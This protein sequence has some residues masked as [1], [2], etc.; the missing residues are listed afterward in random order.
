M[1]NNIYSYNQF[2]IKSIIK[3]K[4]TIFENNQLMQI[5]KKKANILH[6]KNNI[7]SNN[8]K[9]ISKLLLKSENLEIWNSS[10]KFLRKK[11]YSLKKY[12]YSLS[13][14][15]RE[16]AKNLLPNKK[17]KLGIQYFYENQKIFGSGKGMLYS[18]GLLFNIGNIYESIISSQS[19]Y[20]SNIITRDIR[21]KLTVSKMF[22]PSYFRFPFMLDHYYSKILKISSQSAHIPI[23][24]NAHNIKET[25]LYLNYSG[26][27]YK[28]NKYWINLETS[29]YNELLIKHMLNL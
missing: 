14:N 7:L 2:N 22:H 27:K 16:F 20:Y 4:N 17:N 19:H 6:S 3:S 24:L 28:S 8:K 12:Y 26:R 13:K 18:H 11:D 29:Y 21:I 9:G 15:S 10:T 23:I 1:I 5:S 25:R